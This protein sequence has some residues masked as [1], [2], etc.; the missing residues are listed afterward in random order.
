[1]N[2]VQS[3]GCFEVFNRIFIVLFLLDETVCGVEVKRNQKLGVAFEIPD[4]FIHGLFVG[5]HIEECGRGFLAVRDRLHDILVDFAVF[6][7]V[8]EIAVNI[9]AVLHELSAAGIAESGENAERLRIC[10]V[11]IEESEFANPLFCGCFA[12]RFVIRLGHGKQQG[13]ERF[14][15]AVG[16]ESAHAGIVADGIRLNQRID[17]FFRFDGLTWFFLRESRE[18]DGREDCECGKSCRSNFVHTHRILLDSDIII[19]LC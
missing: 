18:R 19:S 5:I 6:D 15:F 4:I 7:F 11:R 16:A 2:D 12:L 9:L 1:M 8:R 10:L 17:L 14:V 3:I 13:C